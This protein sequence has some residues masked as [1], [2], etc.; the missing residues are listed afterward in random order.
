M[1]TGNVNGGNSANVARNTTQVTAQS[2]IN[3]MNSAA[4][5]N[6][7]SSD[8]QAA[9]ETRKN[10]KKSVEKHAQ[11]Q[12]V[13][14]K[15][16]VL[17]REVARSALAQTGT[18]AFNPARDGSSSSGLTHSQ[19]QNLLGKVQN[20]LSYLTGSDS[21][22]N[23][24][25][26]AE[27]NGAF[28]SPNAP[29]MTSGGNT[30][31]AISAL[32]EV[33]N[34]TFKNTSK[35][36]LAFA[37]LS[38]NINDMTL[39]YLEIAL[40]AQRQSIMGAYGEG[41][42]SADKTKKSGLIN[43]F[44]A[45][46][47]VGAMAQAGFT[48]TGKN[49]KAAGTFGDSTSDT[50][51]N[52]LGALKG[53]A[54]ATE[55]A[56]SAITGGNLQKLNG[57]ITQLF[58]EGKAGLEGLPED[59]DVVAD[60]FKS[61]KNLNQATKQYRED[62]IDRLEP[63]DKDKSENPY[64]DKKTNKPYVQGTPEEREAR[65]KRFC[66]VVTEVSKD[67][68]LVNE[69]KNTPLF[70][71]TDRVGESRLRKAAYAVESTLH[72]PTVVNEP[73][74]LKV[75]NLAEVTTVVNKKEP[76]H[77]VTDATSLSAALSGVGLQ[78]TNTIGVV[79]TPAKNDVP[80]TTR[81]TA[82]VVAAGPAAE[83]KFTV[84][85]L[86]TVNEIHPSGDLSDHGIECLL[87]CTVDAET[88]TRIRTKTALDLHDGTSA[89][90]FS[91]LYKSGKDFSELGVTSTKLKTNLENARVEIDKLEENPAL[92]DVIDEKLTLGGTLL[93]RD[94]LQTRIATVDSKLA[95]LAPDASER[96]PME[97]YL[98]KLQGAQREHEQFSKISK[99]K[100]GLNTPEYKK[101]Q[102][103]TDTNVKV[104]E[105]HIKTVIEEK[106]Y[107]FKTFQNYA[108]DSDQLL[109]TFKDKIGIGG[110]SGPGAKMVAEA[111]QRDA[112]KSRN[113]HFFNG[114][115]QSIGITSAV[116]ATIH[117]Q[118]LVD[119]VEKENIN[120]Q[121]DTMSQK[122]SAVMQFNNNQLTQ[123]EGGRNNAVAALGQEAQALSQA[124][125]ANGGR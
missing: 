111:Q 43:A 69:A 21:F 78:G 109:N 89:G 80:E 113:G 70:A 24:P 67:K 48:P 63:L 120:H 11:M 50:I 123:V 79:V 114:A 115:F 35:N 32:F 6:R 87:E 52:N 28:H 99:R 102:E 9:D 86:S 88:A 117:A 59:L 26:L 19:E 64:V 55:D 72:A 41:L 12:Q 118:S 98:S 57:R 4:K 34:E 13:T 15:N 83:G 92:K 47:G 14:V 95:S 75:S 125:N 18:D 56:V 46:Q 22:K 42:D 5:R 53:N 104:L 8:S 119:T 49:P 3:A 45:L 38:V 1:S 124:I 85:I 103:A 36:S 74:M 2:F 33:F 31:R 44:S 106:D 29:V 37:E 10:E 39:K 61:G 107:K 122:T 23:T 82:I 110:G 62:I 84:K 20:T 71:K 7:D 25:R 116:G 90:L 65:F 66:D 94:A 17:S 51:V 105:D 60:E 40:E 91:K 100:E 93:E 121:K 16:P 96:K 101:D 77:T 97:A 30:Q 112:V 58:K 76:F 54:T 81:I 68:K 108:A 73:G 27:K